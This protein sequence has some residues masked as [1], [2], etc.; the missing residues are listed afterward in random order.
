MP[1]TRTTIV[2]DDALIEEAISLSPVQT[3]KDTIILAL[4]EFINTR[5]RKDLSALKGSI[6]FSEGYDY[7]KMRT[8]GEA[9]L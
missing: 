9:N 2:L 5:K 4:E 8:E 7:K 6:R 3:K 1:E